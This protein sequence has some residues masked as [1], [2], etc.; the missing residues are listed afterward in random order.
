MARVILCDWCK[1]RMDANS[2]SNIQVHTKTFEVCTKCSEEIVRRLESVETDAQPVPPSHARK[3]SEAVEKAPVKQEQDVDETGESSE[4]LGDNEL[5][6]VPSQFDKRKA[7]R[8]AAELNG[9][10]CTHPFTSFEDGRIVCSAPPSGREIPAEY[11][12]HKPCGAV[13]R[14]GQRAPTRHFTL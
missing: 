14:G 4:E 6:T 13:I 8:A 12:N 5:H 7:R 11:R 3:I 1:S 2:L 9:G 10:T